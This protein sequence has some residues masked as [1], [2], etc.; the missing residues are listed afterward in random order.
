MKPS[1]S[2]QTRRVFFLSLPIFAELLLQLLVGNVDQF[3]L[4]H[5]G[6][7]AVSAVGNGNQV[8]HVIVIVLETVSSATTILLTQNLGAGKAG[9]KCGEI[10]T[11]GVAL[12]AIFS[13]LV[14]LVT[15][16][17]P[18]VLFTVLQ[19]P[20]EAFDGACLYLRIYLLGMPALAMY[21]FGNAVLGA[22]GDTK[23]PLYYLFFAGI[24]NVLLNLFFVIVCKMGVAGVALASILSQYLSA[25]LLLR[26][27]LQSKEDFGLRPSCLRISRDKLKRL[28]QIG[29]PS[30][31]QNAIFA[32]ANLFVQTSVNSFDHVMVEGNSA[33][34]N[35]D[36]LVYDMMA[37]IY[38]GCTSFMAQN[39]GAGK[40]DRVM[41]SYKIC[42]L[43]SFLLGLVLGVGLYALKTPFLSLFTSDA[44]VITAGYKRLSVMA[45]SYCL[46]AFMDCT[47]AASRGMGKTFVPTIIVILGSCGFRILW[48]YTVFAHFRTIESLYLLYAFSWSITAIAEMI[49]F[50]KLFHSTNTAKA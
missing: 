9:E 45:L 29:I 47:I 20:A 35:A 13:I 27:L 41:K 3:M 38:T 28:L 14:G 31:F 8:M 6:T 46:S 22:A 24:L 1:A 50:F 12:G 36:P 39:L 43:Y 10:A 32:I 42:L 5:V 40:R 33:A 23:R 26:L 11:V 16:F 49:Y 19:T 4:S 48:I 17:L 7:A 2:P 37:G 15:L 44:A 21:N 34:I 25:F 30:A 18:H